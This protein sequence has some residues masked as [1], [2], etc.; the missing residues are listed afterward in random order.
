MSSKIYSGGLLVLFLILFSCKSDPVKVAA[1]AAQE[2]N[3]IIDSTIT[4]FQKKLLAQQIDS[5]FSKTKFNGSISVI[6]NGEKLYEKQNGF[7]DFKTKAKLDSNSVFAIGSLS[8]QFTAV[9]VLLQEEQSKL[10]IN[11]KVSKYLVEFQPKEFE[12]I[13]IQQL[14]NHTSGLNDFGSGLLSKPGKE[15]NYSNKGFRYLGELVE[16]VS[17]KSYDENAKELFAKAGMKNSSTPN[18]FQGKDFAG[19][20]TGNS[21]NFQKIDNMPKRLADKEISVAA[22]GILSTV[23]DLHRW[24]DAL[25]NGRILKPESLQK[26]MEKSSGRN[27]PILG[28][29]GYGFG[30][31]MNPQKP[32]AYFH[33]GYVKGSPSLSIYYPET[34]TSVIILS[35]IA[36]ESK[37]KD[38]IFIPHKEVKKIADSLEIKVDELRIQLQNQPI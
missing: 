6:R 31:M 21:N 5:V 35:N 32:V 19:A 13:T 30:I 34:K 15:F 1:T 27:H 4:A 26:F 17:G 16:K 10:K 37:G 8:K 2:R 25:Y 33:T 29:M 23:P 14:L 9:L 18:L 20:Y 38:A 11:D 28:K 24:N 12:N 36:D 3:I 22:G 7:E